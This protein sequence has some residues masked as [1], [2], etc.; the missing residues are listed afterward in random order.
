MFR[1]PFN[2]ISS[3]EYDSVP[4]TTQSPEAGASEIFMI[5]LLSFS[6]ELLESAGATKFIA[7][8]NVSS[9]VSSDSGR[10]VKQYSV[11]SVQL[12]SDVLFTT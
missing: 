5:A 1:L 6:I 4:E 2:I 12:P 11:L 10:V 7:E 3:S 9:T 8:G